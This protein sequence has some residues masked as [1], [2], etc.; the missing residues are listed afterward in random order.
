[1]IEKLKFILRYALVSFFCASFDYILFLTLYIKF[2]LD[3]MPAFLISY[4]I[5]SVT[6]FFGLAYFTFRVNTVSLKNALYFLSQLIFVAI[7]GFIVLRG[8][9]LLLDAKYAKL[10]QI[11]ST[12]IFSLIYGKFITFNKSP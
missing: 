10:V 2:H 7:I 12:F 8:A 5:V 3:L 1:M 11:F 9:L 4:T 6:G